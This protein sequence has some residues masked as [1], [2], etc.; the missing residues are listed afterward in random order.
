MDTLEVAKAQKHLTPEQQDDLASLLS[1]Y[2]KLFSGKLGLYPNKKLHFELMPNARPVYKRPY[3]VAHAHRAV[4]KQE[5][6]RLVELNVLEPCGPSAWGA[7]TFII[8]KKDGRV[9]W[10]SDFR[11]LNKV[12]KRKVYPLPR[13]MDIIQRRKGYKYFSKLDISMHYYTFEL[14]EE[15][16]DLCVIVTPFGNY[17]YTRAPMGVKQSPDFAQEVM[18]TLFRAMDEIEVYIDDVG[19]FNDDWP[20]HLKTLD[21]VLDILQ[22]NNFTV[23]PLKCDWGVQETDFLGYWLTPT[24]VK[25]MRKKIDAILQLQPPKTRKQL[26]SFIGA[27]EATCRSD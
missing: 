7:P 9:R 5:L 8:P 12:I 17:R 27:R 24:G 13:I 6:D 15:S 2:T 26:R 4:F 10:V 16:K 22:R 18:E 25:P 1:K 20:S 23:N 11:E 14:T 19:C 3:T 21:K